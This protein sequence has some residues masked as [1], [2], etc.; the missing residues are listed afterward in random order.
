MNH[1][2]DVKTAVEMWNIIIDV[3]QRKTLLNCLNALRRF[4]SVNM[5]DSDC[6]FPFIN[7]FR[8]L[9]S[10]LRPLHVEI[11]NHESAMTV[12]CGLFTKF[13][14]RIVAIDSVDELMTLTVDLVKSIL[15]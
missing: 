13:E 8:Q 10:D 11:S 15:L 5:D 3:F 12:L 4:Y 1:F 2:R 6:I 7:R 14:D 9:F